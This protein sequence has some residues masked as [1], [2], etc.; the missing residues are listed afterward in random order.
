MTPPTYAKG[1]TV[2]AASSRAEIENTI[3]R[4]K[5]DGFA[6]G[7]QGNRATVQF[8]A[9]GRQIRFDLTLPDSNS[10]Q[11]TQYRRSPHSTPTRRTPDAAAKMYEQAI[12]ELW[13]ALALAVKAKLAAVEAGIASFEDEFLAYVVMPDGR[14]VG[15]TIRPEVARAYELGTAPLQLLPG[16]S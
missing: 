11:F 14:T 3:A 9:Q 4:F 12:R 15:E 8:L 1:T 10:P 5:A 16:P 6:F 7:T 13:R 2:S